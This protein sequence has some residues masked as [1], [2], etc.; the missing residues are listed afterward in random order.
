[1]RTK[2]VKIY[3]NELGC[4][5]YTTPSIGTVNVRILLSDVS[6]YELECEVNRINWDIIWLC[7]IRRKGERIFRITN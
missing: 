2:G 6:Q 1:M 3:W 7:E 5:K 4:P